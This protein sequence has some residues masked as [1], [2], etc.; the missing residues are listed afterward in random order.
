V[1]CESMKG[2]S[3][4][5]SRK[6][7]TLFDD[8]QYDFKFFFVSGTVN[9]DLSPE[10]AKRM[11]FAPAQ[12]ANLVRAFHGQAEMA[13]RVTHTMNMDRLEWFLGRQRGL[14]RAH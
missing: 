6:I 5:S 9:H 1:K 8:R 4:E 2:T 3:V 13:A 14:W 12:L 11:D 7:Q 10:V